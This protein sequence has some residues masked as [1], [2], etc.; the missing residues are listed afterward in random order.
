VFE[1]SKIRGG[2][3][4]VSGGLGNEKPSQNRRTL[5]KGSPSYPS[6]PEAVE[7]ASVTGNPERESLSD[8]R[9]PLRTPQKREKATGMSW[10]W[11]Y[12]RLQS[13]IAVRHFSK[14][15]FHAYRSWIRKLQNFTQ[16]KDPASLE[17][18]EVKAFLTALAVEHKVAASSQNQAFN[19]L[20]FLFRHILEKPFE[21]VEGVVRAKRKPY[22]PVVLSRDEVDRIIA[23]HSDPYDLI[24]KLLYGCGLR[25]FECMKLRVQDLNLDLRILTVHDGKGQKD[26]TVPLPVVLLPDL[27]AQLETAT[28]IHQLD[29]Q[30]GYAGTFLPTAVERKYKNAA[31][32]L[33]WQMAF[34]SY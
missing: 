32:E 21:K 6:G 29:L 13:S 23:H 25:L 7:P 28:Q 31:K 5:A 33:V 20:L 18:E 10:V 22:I 24:T 26:R 16:S 1:L 11:V 2:L 19:A 17:M 8:R 4:P 15:M 30:A 9:G 27:R 34:S 12:E 14:K 3:P